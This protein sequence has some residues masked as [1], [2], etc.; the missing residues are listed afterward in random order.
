MLRLS[1]LSQKKKAA[2]QQRG[3]LAILGSSQSETHP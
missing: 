2:L 3:L 1:Q